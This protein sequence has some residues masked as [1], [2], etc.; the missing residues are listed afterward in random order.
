VARSPRALAVAVVVFGF[1]VLAGCGGGGSSGGTVDVTL[2]DY[3][4]ILSSG[5]VG[6]G[7]VDLAIDNRGGFV[8]E[9]LLVRSG[10]AVDE[11]PKTADGRFDEKGAGVRIVAAARDIPAGGATEIVEKLT[12]GGYYLICNRPA[13]PGDALSHFAHGMFAPFTVS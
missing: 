11:L 3:D 1:V 13:E 10:L 2:T 12:A 8:H 5:S 7:T 9:V 4:V 6:A